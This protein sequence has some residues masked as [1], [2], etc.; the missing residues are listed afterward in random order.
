[1]RLV[2]LAFNTHEILTTEGRLAEV[3]FNVGRYAGLHPLKIEFAEISRQPGYST[4]HVWVKCSTLEPNDVVGRLSVHI[5]AISEN[6]NAPDLGGTP[7]CA[8]GA[9]LFYGLIGRPGMRLE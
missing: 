6:E 1:M 3:E 9:W 7:L 2:R 4:L 5:Q 8:H